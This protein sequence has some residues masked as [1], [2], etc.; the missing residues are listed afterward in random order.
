MPEHDEIALTG[1][2]VTQ[3]VVRIGDR[4]RRP[5]TRNADFVQRLLKHLRARGFDGAPAALGTD[6]D[7]RDVFTFI[8]GDVPT[9]LGFH[10]DATLRRAAALIRRIHDLGAELVATPAATAQGIE[11]VCHNDL[12]PC[13][14]VFR[15]GVPIAMIDFDAAAP[16]SRAYDLG[17]AAWLWLDLGS[18]ETAAE[19]QRRRLR[20]FLD[21]YGTDDDAGIVTAVLRRQAILVAEGHRRGDEAMAEWATDCLRWTE[22]HRRL[23][24]G[25]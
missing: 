15:G 6:A 24:A 1:G 2:R 18:P 21:A 14:F 12:S 19:E 9:D 4:V 22:A 16:G 8:E 7:G 3:S 5:P 11:V 13:N 23:L 20:L 10:D 25:I 17:Y